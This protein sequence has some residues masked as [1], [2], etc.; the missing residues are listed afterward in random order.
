[1]P[2]SFYDPKNSEGLKQRTMACNAALDDLIEYMRQDD[3]RIGIYDATN[4]TQER[5]K[6]ISDKLR[7]SGIG[8]KLMCIETICDDDEL[9]EENIR[10]VKLST[11]DYR[12]V[13]PEQALADFQ[14]RRENYASVYETL[15][16]SWGSY[17]KIYNSK[18]FVVNNIRGY[19]P[20]KVVHFVMNLHTLPRTFYLTRHGQSE[21]NLLGKIGGDSG[22]SV[23][24]VEYA[25]RLATFANDVIAVKPDEGGT[26]EENGAVNGEKVKHPPRPC[27]LWTSTMRRT[28]ETAAFIKHENIVPEWDNGDKVDWIQFRPMAR[29]NLDELYAGVCDG[30]TYKEIEEIYPEEFDRRQSD[31]L[32]Y[33]YPRGESYMDV[34]LR[35]EPLAHEMERTREPLL[36]IAHQGILRILYAYFMGMSREEAPYVSI[37]L[38]TIIQLTPHA[39]GC[40][41]KRICLMQK[42]EMFVDGQDEPVTSMGKKRSSSTTLSSDHIDPV[43]NAPSC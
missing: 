4:S 24:G 31:K 41:E 37:P 12:G 21:Y 6:H 11:P 29:R 13:D 19:L 28:N 40:Q 22:L 25:R 30:M 10:T 3:V 23:A 42:E 14:K 43:M 17:V 15:D 26:T 36:I 27:R 8:A 39:Y 7:N 33:R 35:L 2:A 18:R 16:D 38:N 5:R 9:L 1:M 34:T 20:L 32:A